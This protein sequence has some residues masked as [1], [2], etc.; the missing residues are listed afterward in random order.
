MNKSPY[1]AGMDIEVVIPVYTI[2]LFDK[3]KNKDN[4]LC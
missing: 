2:M 1:T 3:L 4:K